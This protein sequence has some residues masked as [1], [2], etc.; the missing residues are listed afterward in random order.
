[1]VVGRNTCG[2][3]QSLVKWLRKKYSPKIKHGSKQATPENISIRIKV[4]KNIA[5]FL[6]QN[7]KLACLPAGN[8]IRL[9]IN[10]IYI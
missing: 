8:G 5:V 1:M 2:E 3:F 9:I 4:I 7:E 6:I 10:H